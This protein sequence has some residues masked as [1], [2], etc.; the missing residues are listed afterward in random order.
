MITDWLVYQERGF[1]TPHRVT[2]LTVTILLVIGDHF[3]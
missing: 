2:C 1:Q 3:G